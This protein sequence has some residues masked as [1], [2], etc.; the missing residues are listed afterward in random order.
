MSVV[1]SSFGSL[2]PENSPRLRTLIQL[3]Q[4]TPIISISSPEAIFSNLKRLR[5]LDMRSTDLS[6][7]PN[8]VNKLKHLRY[9]NLSSTS[10]TLL[11]NEH[12]CSLINLQTLKLSECHD[13]IC[14][15]Q[16]MRKL[17]NLRH[18]DI[19]GCYKLTQM[20]KDMGKLISLQT[21]SLFIVGEDTGCGITELKELDHLKG[22]LVIKGLEHVKNSADAGNSNLV[23]KQY[24]ES[25]KLYWSSSRTGTEEEIGEVLDIHHMYNLEKFSSPLPL[26]LSSLRSSASRLKK[27]PRGGQGQVLAF[28][29]L[30]KLSI[31]CCP[32]LIES[33]S[34]PSSLKELDIRNS[35]EMVVLKCFEK[36]P[37]CLSHLKIIGIPN[38][39]SFTMVAEEEKGKLSSLT[40]LKIKACPK[41]KTLP[42]EFSEI[43]SSLTHI[44]II[45]CSELIKLPEGMHNLNSLKI[46]WIEDC[47]GLQSLNSGL[48]HLTTL[49]ELRICDCPE[50]E[51]LSED[52]QN[53]ISLQNL[54]LEGLPKIT[55][56][57]PIAI[58]GSGGSSQQPISTV[59]RTLTR[60]TII[61]CS[62]LTRLPEWLS[63]RTSLEELEILN[64]KNCKLLPA[65]LQRHTDLTFLTIQ[66]C[67]P[68]LHKRCEKDKGDYWHKIA[69]IKYLSIENE[70]E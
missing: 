36:L 48:L 12:F 64:C 29:S 54:A 63:Y 19:M 44:K 2:L 4:Y 43:F 28:P 23:R 6:V 18:L 41:L 52:F 53:L 35:H 27:K 11:P 34:L 32:K 51:F 7:I 42:N 69:H 62:G 24:L 20:P 49:E 3:Q 9:L 14:L 33:I 60:I 50:L 39:V 58:C 17:T 46:L 15:P 5:A 45:R 40:H 61:S 10:I 30:K 38:L 22:E 68:D 57:P 31:V 26:S 21:L 1:D 55:D 47:R 37:S 8:S 66:N 16:E 70:E 25:L 13:L 67:H 59:L 56:L 65:G